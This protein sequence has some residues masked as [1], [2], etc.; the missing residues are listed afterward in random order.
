MFASRNSQG[1][2]RAV[3]EA[4]EWL[5]SEDWEIPATDIVDPALTPDNCHSLTFEGADLGQDDSI[6]EFI[7]TWRRFP[8]PVLLCLSDGKVA[9]SARLLGNDTWRQTLPGGPIF[10]TDREMLEQKYE[11][12]LLTDD[13]EMAA[14]LNVQRQSET[15][16]ATARNN[17][18]SKWRH[19]S[20]FNPER[21]DAARELDYRLPKW[22]SLVEVGKTED[23]RDLGAAAI[24]DWD[25]QLLFL[26][27]RVTSER[28]SE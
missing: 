18:L 1:G 4:E 22:R 10:Q 17:F 5:R 16:T 12:Y 15:E 23:E 19:M 27:A 14:L 6:G 24:E 9:H 28:R 7:K 20:V 2:L 25:E 21:S 13:G 26:L 3:R 8:G 11:C